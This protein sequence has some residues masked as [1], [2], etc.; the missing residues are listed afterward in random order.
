MNARI[1]AIETLASQVDDNDPVKTELLA[2]VLALK[3]QILEM[4]GG[5]ND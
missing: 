1:L 5:G 2:E 4:M 3:A